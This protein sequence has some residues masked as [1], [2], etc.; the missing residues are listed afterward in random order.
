MLCSCLQL[1]CEREQPASSCLAATGAEVEGPEGQG[2]RQLQGCSTVGAHL[3]SAALFR[4]Q[5]PLPRGETSA[6]NLRS[7]RAGYFWQMGGGI[8][9]GGR[10]WHNESDGNKL[11]YSSGRWESD[12]R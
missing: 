4:G 11:Y 6:P 3:F 9:F 5:L 12:P 1:F 10:L 2:G 7:S 8:Y